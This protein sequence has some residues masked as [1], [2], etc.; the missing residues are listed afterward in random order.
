M[1]F[2]RP[3]EGEAEQR[4]GVE[5]CQ[6]PVCWCVWWTKSFWLITKFLKASTDLIWDSNPLLSVSCYLQTHIRTHRDLLYML[7]CCLC[8][9]CF[10]FPYSFVCLASHLIFILPLWHIPLNVFNLAAFP[11]QSHTPLA[12]SSAGFVLFILPLSLPLPLAWCTSLCCLSL[13]SETLWAVASG[14]QRKKPANA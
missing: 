11:N 6:A 5:L 4:A 2:R 13:Q 9:F 14:L 12:D 1:L 7:S 3:C 8:F 10:F